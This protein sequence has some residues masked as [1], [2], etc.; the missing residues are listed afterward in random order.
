VIRIRGVPHAEEKAEQQHGEKRGVHEG[1][2]S[3]A[4]TA[5]RSVALAGEGDFHDAIFV[6]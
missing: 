1:G 5:D 4:S 6:Q 2:V 3:L